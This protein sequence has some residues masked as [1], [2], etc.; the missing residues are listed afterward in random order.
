MW[1]AFSVLVIFSLFQ[2]YAGSAETANSPIAV[3]PTVVAPAIVAPVPAPPTAPLAAK[4]VMDTAETVTIDSALTGKADQAGVTAAQTETVASTAVPTSK[5]TILPP[6][7][8]S[9]TTPFLANLDLGGT[10]QLKAFYHNFA[11]D[12]DKDKRLSLTLRRF[13]LDLD[14]AVDSHLGFK[15]GFLV[16][17]NNK[18][19][20]IDDAFLYYSVNELVGFKGGKLKRPFSQEALQ[21]SKSLYTI[22]RGETYHD[23][24]T[25][26]TGYAYYDVGLMAYGGFVEEGRSVGYELGI[27]N[28]KQ[29]GDASKDYSG[30]HYEASDKGFIAKDVVMRITAVPFRLLKVEAAVSTKAAEDTTNPA[31]FEYNVNTA[32]EIGVSYLDKQLKLLGEVSW[33]DNHNKVDALILN[34]SSMFFAFYTTAVWHSD[35]PRGRASELVL[36]LEG[37]DPDFEPGKGE[38]KPNDG[39]LRYTLGTNYF[40]SPRLSLMGNY[41]ILQPVTEVTGEGDLTHSVDALVR[42]TF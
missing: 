35:Y 10:V 28:G 24:L 16:D 25:N 22:E 3:K 29:N 19:F 26:V 23:F 31:S 38:G 2:T 12:R 40:F 32:Y 15:A 34:G 21:S 8:I 30:Q 1:Q 36:K 39:L 33:G 5:D 11:A 20:G 13:K 9:I 17:G 27:F 4:E 37:L 14:G 18:N 7:A 41:G 42:L 6:E